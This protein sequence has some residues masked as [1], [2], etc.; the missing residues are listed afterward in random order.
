M[1]APSLPKRATLATAIMLLLLPLAR[2]HAQDATQTPA[3]DT[4]HPQDTSSRGHIKTISGVVVTSSALQDT[5]D[6]LSKP[7]DVLTGARL[8]ENRGATLGETVASLP[9]VQSSNFGPGVGRPI[10]RG[11]DGPRVAVLSGGLSSQ[12][13]STVSQDHAPAIEPFLADQIEVL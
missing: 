12:D 8:D 7:A 2:A 6:T 9:G 5:A 3:S 4:R 1:Q 13:V 10:I 11:L